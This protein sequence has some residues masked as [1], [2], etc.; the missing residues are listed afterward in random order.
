MMSLN[1]IQGDWYDGVIPSNVELGVNAHIDTSYGLALIDST[2]RPCLIMAAG[3]GSYTTS[4]VIGP[5]GRVTVGSCTCLNSPFLICQE[6]I[7][8]GSHCLVSW[9]AVITDTDLG[10]RESRGTNQQMLRRAAADPDRRLAP[11][12]RPLPV[13]IEDAVWIGF[14]SVV[15]P[16]VTVGRGSVIGCKTV[17]DQDIPPYVVVAGN[18]LRV[19]RELDPPGRDQSPGV[20]PG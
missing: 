10:Q 6:S 19:V 14:G 8:I 16:G 3:S 4:F 2:R 12:T 7:T 15:M 20:V 17:V 5:N 1:R 9:G 11:L 13:I 18:P